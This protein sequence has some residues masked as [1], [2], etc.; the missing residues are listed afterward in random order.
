VRR[1]L[2]PVA[3]LVIAAAPQARAAYP[4]T[5]GQIAFVG[6]RGG[7]VQLYLR[8]SG[9]TAGLLAGPLEAPAWS[10]R[11]VRIAVTRTAPDGSNAIWIMRPHGAELRQL[12]PAGGNDQDPTWAP[13]AGRLALTAGTTGSRTIDVVRAD[14]TGR[15]TILSAPGTDPHDPAWSVR[16]R[17]AFVATAPAG[18]G[19]ED[20]FV[21]DS[22]GTNVGRLTHKPGNDTGPAWSP[23]GRLIAFVRGRGGIWVMGADGRG[24][25]RVV[26]VKGGGESA[27]AFSPDGRRIV[28]S[29]GRTGQRQIWAVDL[30]GR[31]LRALSLPGSDGHAPDWQP[32]GKDPIVLAA[33]DIA[34]DPNSHYFNNGIGAAR[35]CGEWRTSNLLLDD[36]EAAV[37]TLGD[38]QYPYGEYDK[39]LASF[40]PTWGRMKPLIHPTS[41]NHEYGNGKTEDANADGY[42]TYFDGVPSSYSFDVGTWHVISLNSNCEQVPGGCGDGSPEQQWLAQDLAAHPSRCTLAFWHYPVFSSEGGLAAMAAMYRTLYDA[43]A[44]VVLTGHHHIYERFAPQNPDGGVDSARGIREFI[45]GT[46]GMSLDKPRTQLANSQVINATTFGVL[47]LELKSR[48]Y[49]W[50]FVSASADPFA[51]SGTGLC[52]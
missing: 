31:H 46:G 48:S 36:D 28:F 12:T 43:G 5:N 33:G 23:N 14:G 40:G 42:Y 13:G 35:H 37:L 17:I 7:Q 34:C 21:M 26:H 10:P 8:S 18:N 39:F 47:R 1:L 52:H 19:G 50:R 24:A 3:L 6:A 25:R 29:A 38:E 16:D 2:L 20:V 11:G 9:H 30:D 51:D 45:V 44:D 27:P 4:G 41:G 49:N 15:H 32:A 22:D